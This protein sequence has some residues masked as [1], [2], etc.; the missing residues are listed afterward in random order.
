MSKEEQKL[1]LAA[2]KQRLVAEGELHRLTTLHAKM[3][4]RQ[5][6]RPEALLHGAVDHAVGVA[7][8]RLGGLL[9]PG[10]LSQLN[11]K[12][13]M[14]YALTVGSFIVRK[15][16]YKP[17]LAVA[18][19]AAAGAAWLLRRKRA[20]VEDDAGVDEAPWE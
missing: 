15:R 12:T 9:S 6:L 4:L 19:V 7:Q 17:A 18:A 13:I 8:S 11:F 2:A 16:L 10:G 5:A 14:P 3:Q 1:A 20:E